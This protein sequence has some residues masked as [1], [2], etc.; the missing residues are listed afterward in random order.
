M[1][2]LEQQAAGLGDLDLLPAELAIEILE[3]S[4][5]DEP[6]CVPKEPGCERARC[7]IRE[8]PRKVRKVP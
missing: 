4:L 2:L 5:R 7:M 6:L 3:M 1:S 8:T